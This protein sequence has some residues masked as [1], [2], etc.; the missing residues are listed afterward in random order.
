MQR[1]AVICSMSKW[2]PEINGFPQEFVLGQNPFIIFIND[3]YSGVKCNFSKFADDSEMSGA[4]DTWGMPSRGS[5][6]IL[7]TGPRWISWSSTRPSERSCIWVRAIPIISMNGL[8]AILRRTGEWKIGYELT[9]CTYSP[10][11]QPYPGLH[12]KQCGHQG[13]EGNFAPLFL[14]LWSSTCSAA[15]SCGALTRWKTWIS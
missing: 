15:S 3:I 11:N 4:V 10:E 12:P 13:K 6:T 8:R 14:F 9:I 7:R 5:L 2:K 1:V